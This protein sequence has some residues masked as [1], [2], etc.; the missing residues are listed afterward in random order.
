MT[1]RA[2][3]LDL[4][5]A[6]SAEGMGQAALLGDEEGGRLSNGNSAAHSFCALVKCLQGCDLTLGGYLKCLAARSKFH[7]K[8][9]LCRLTKTGTAWLT[10]RESAWKLSV[11]MA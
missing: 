4:D 9:K 1:R 10:T 2:S 5:H 6:A 8:C 11:G 3:W 7:S